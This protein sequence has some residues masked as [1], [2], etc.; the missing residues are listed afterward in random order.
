MA[1][2]GK[3]ALVMRKKGGLG[4][5]TIHSAIYRPVVNKKNGEVEFVLNQDSPVAQ[6]E[7]V[8]VDEAS[9][10]NAELGND[11]LQFGV[12]VLVLGDPFQI[13]PVKGEGF[14]TSDN[15]DVMLTEIHRQAIDNP[16]IRMSFDIREGRSIVG[17][18]Y[19]ESKV[20]ARKLMNDPRF[21]KIFIEADQILCG[22]NKTRISLNAHVRKLKG[23]AN[24]NDIYEPTIGD[25]L[26]CIKNDRRK[27]LLNGGMWNVETINKIANYYDIS[28]SSL[29]DA[30]NY[31]VDVKV[32][33]HFFKGTESELDWRVRKSYDEFTFG[34]VLTVHKSQGSQWDKVLVI[35]ESPVFREHSARHLYTAVTRAAEK[36]WVAV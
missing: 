26:V 11:L 30:S 2:T 15:P 1:Y 17:Q 12:K 4:A 32:S 10:V 18:D 16:I 7:L 9:M 28:V 36:V 5:S 14:F 8:I 21:S 35:D 29:D 33:D 24:P 31:D 23:I 6:A 27:G 34:N 22:M 19:G 13:P 20:F 25:K 3:A